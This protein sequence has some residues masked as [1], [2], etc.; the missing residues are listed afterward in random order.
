MRVENG[1][2]SDRQRTVLFVSISGTMGGPGSSLATVIA[3]MPEDLTSVLAA[4]APGDLVTQ[5]QARGSLGDLLPLPSKRGR[6]ATPWSRARAA[7]TL[8][9]WLLMNRQDVLC[10]H[11][12]GSTE[13]HLSAI[14]AAAAGIPLVV[15]F[16]ASEAEKWDRRLGRIW[17]RLPGDRLYVA[18]SPIAAEA[19][20]SSGVATISEISIVPNPIDPRDCVGRRA[21]RDREHPAEVVVGFLGGTSRP[22]KGFQH[23]PRIVAAAGDS[24]RWIVF[25]NRRA[26]SPQEQAWKSLDQLPA[27][28]VMVVG[29][30]SPVREA[31][32][33]CD[34]VC[35][36]SVRESFNRVVAEAMANGLPVVASDIPAHRA[37]LAGPGAG[38]LF[39][40]EQ[41]ELGG[42]AI[43]ML[44][45]NR[46]LR[47][48]LGQAGMSAAR[49]FDPLA[50][51]ETLV[52]LYARSQLPERRARR[53]AGQ[54]R[55]RR[56]TRGY[57]A[58]L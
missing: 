57:R 51:V 42:E 19:A 38:I 11:A 46:A 27:G 16:H 47:E 20:A 10:V 56:N 25:G 54:G 39:P 49:A 52:A 58:D 12:N 7:T 48:Q 45:T 44:A 14:G 4:P 3:N 18:V 5:V 41:P 6:I 53:F 35:C 8:M 15:V 36:P 26:D 17:H 34:I 33:E 50:V 55:S 30:R 29:R 31:Y 2:N 37:L 23:L 9:R 28:R 21:D 43:A 13:L 22:D 40:L 24:A 32:A 1:V